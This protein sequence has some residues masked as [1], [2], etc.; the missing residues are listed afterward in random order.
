MDVC[1]RLSVLSC[2]DRG[3]CDG[4]ITRPRSPTDH[5][6]RLEATSPPLCLHQDRSNMRQTLILYAE[7][8]INKS[9]WER[10][11]QSSEDRVRGTSGK[12]CILGLNVTQIM[13]I[14]SIFVAYF[15]GLFNY[16][17]AIVFV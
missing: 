2:V 16:T 12:L 7:H 1:P 3:L 13:Q 11:S 8:K 17:V 14:Y 4:L 9:L 15:L 6:T 10:Y 5:A